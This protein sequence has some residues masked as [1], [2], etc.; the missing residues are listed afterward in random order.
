MCLISHDLKCWTH[1]ILD[2][3]HSAVTSVLVSAPYS[4]L[5]GVWP[6]N[7]IRDRVKIHSH[8]I[9]TVSNQRAND[10]RLWG[11]IVW[12]DLVPTG[13]QERHLSRSYI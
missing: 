10:I 7:T 5:G 9:T 2:T 1:D 6:V 8:D 12:Y 3:H 4:V 13:H 11:D